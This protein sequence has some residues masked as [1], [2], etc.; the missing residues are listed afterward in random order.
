MDRKYEGHTP[1]PWDQR[2]RYSSLKDEIGVR[3]KAICT[4]WVCHVIG[5]LRDEQALVADPEGEANARLIADAPTILAQRDRL[6]EALAFYAAPGIYQD[7]GWSDRPRPVI[8]DGG[9]RAREALE[10]TK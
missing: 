7:D 2:S 4:V 8:E 10:E 5:V 3:G 9:K 6:R 1:G